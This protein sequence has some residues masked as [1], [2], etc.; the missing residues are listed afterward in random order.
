MHK[1]VLSSVLGCTKMNLYWLESD[2]IIVLYT[3]WYFLPFF[4]VIG[5]SI[6]PGGIYPNGG[7]IYLRSNY[8]YN[9]MYMVW[10]TLVVSPPQ[11]V[12]QWGRIQPRGLPDPA[13]AI[14]QAAVTGTM[15]S[16]DIHGEEERT[17]ERGENE[18]ESE[19]KTQRERRS[20]PLWWARVGRERSVSQCG[21]IRMCS[22][23]WCG[24]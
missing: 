9:K 24:G 20:P 3:L 1:Q 21:W 16:S 5:V 10:M 8:S 2:W 22:L 17:S 18:R 4:R 19:W 13:Y 14:H 23:T 11:P 15:T 6:F 7:A 12:Q